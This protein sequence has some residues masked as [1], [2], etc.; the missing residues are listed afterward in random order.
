[1]YH[2]Y[3]CIF[4]APSNHLGRRARARNERLGLLDGVP[5]T[6]ET[7]IAQEPA[8]HNDARRG[9]RRWACVRACTT[10]TYIYRRTRRARVRR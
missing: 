8:R 2:G 10:H 3:I 9:A 4:R 7:L 5:R 1:M 6:T